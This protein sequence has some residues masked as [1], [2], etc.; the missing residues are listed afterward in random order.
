MENSMRDEALKIR[1]VEV[2]CDR[3]ESRIGVCTAAQVTVTHVDDTET[4]MDFPEL[5][6]FGDSAET[7]LCEKI[8][9]RLNIDQSL[10][11]ISD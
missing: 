3:D 4:I 6:G 11:I 9:G 7:D 8:A 10:V 2:I 5:E 1:S